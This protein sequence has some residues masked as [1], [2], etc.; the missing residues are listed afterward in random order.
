MKNINIKKE[1]TLNE[2]P[3]NYK[4]RVV[5][6][7]HK[8]FFRRHLMDLS[9]CPG[10]YIKCIDHGHKNGIRCYEICSSIIAIRHAD[11]KKIVINSI[12]KEEF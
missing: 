4:A 8:G 1:F 11:A 6:L 10:A 9:L 7:N 12:E 2:L 3:Y 5:E